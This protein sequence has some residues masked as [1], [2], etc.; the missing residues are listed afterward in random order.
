[1]E[2]H[3]G[4]GI[5]FNI[6]TGFIQLFYNSLL[7]GKTG[8]FIQPHG[9]ILFVFGQMQAIGFSH[10]PSADRLLQ[11]VIEISQKLFLLF[12]AQF[13]DLFHPFYLGYRTVFKYGIQPFAQQ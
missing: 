9:K 6:I 3:L 8:D 13:A 5:S 4:I 12:P 7:L 2:Q 1:M 10:G 11:Q